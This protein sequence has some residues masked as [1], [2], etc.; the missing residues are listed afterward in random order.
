LLDAIDGLP[1]GELE[2]LDL[3]RIQGM[4]HAEA[5]KLLDVSIKT[6]QRRLHRSLLL[7]AGLKEQRTVPPADDAT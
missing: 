7:L 2:V 4:T 5:A 6:I 1:D 3:V